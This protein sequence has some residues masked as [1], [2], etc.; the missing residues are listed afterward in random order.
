MLSVAAR[1][2]EVLDRRGL[3]LAVAESCTGGLI[4]HLLTD[5]PGSSR[6]FPGG[7][8][9]YG[10]QPKRDLLGVSADLLQ[11]HGAVSGE[12]ALAMAEGVRRAMQTDVGVGVTGIAGPTGGSADKPVGTVFIAYAGPGGGDVERHAWVTEPDAGFD[13]GSALRE[14]NK[15]KSALAALALVLRMVEGT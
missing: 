2:V 11:I 3:T 1:V 10:N 8:V 12:T 4:G 5:V 6:V 14:H 9:A 13:N 15:H 7:I